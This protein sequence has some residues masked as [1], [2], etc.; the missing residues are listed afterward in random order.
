MPK[1]TVTAPFYN[2]NT[3]HEAGEVV[4]F[5][6]KRAKEINDKCLSFYDDDVLVSDEQATETPDP[7]AEEATADAEAE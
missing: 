4:E 1:Y 2:G 3:R 5:T 6:A 7:V